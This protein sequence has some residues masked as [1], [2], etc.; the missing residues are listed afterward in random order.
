MRLI[1]ILVLV[2]GAALAGGGIYYASQYMALYKASLQ[3]TNQGPEVARIIVANQR[4][5]YGHKLTPED[6][7]WIDWP[8]S[9]VPEGVF[10][11]RQELFGEDG[12]ERRIVLRTVEKDEPLMKTKLS[13]FDGSTRLSAQL[14][15][16]MRAYTI[17][18]NATSA[19][20][21]FIN[22]GDRVDVIL[23]RTID[24]ELVSGV[25]FADL[26]VIAVDQN[27]DTER[28]RPMAGSTA[29]VEVDGRQAQQLILAQQVGSLTLTLRGV[30]EE[31]TEKIAP[32]T[33]S[34][35]DFTIAK[36]EINAPKAG[37][38]VR[39]RRGT[40][41]GNVQV[42]DTPE[43]REAKRKLLEEERARVEEEIR[44]LEE[45]QTN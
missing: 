11:S 8:K 14:G 43:Q 12:K 5:S 13:G 36:P 9:S 16:G 19:V 2:F 35:I 30:N 24:G 20:A 26:P 34:D 7:R 40:S 38:T 29:T 28:N 37:T 45:E 41:L 27:I 44:R 31:S 21:G 3:Q 32:V 39:V 15:E 42:D 1:A 4:L 6:L 22:P 17:P 18:I 33:L 25:I 10:L 23:T